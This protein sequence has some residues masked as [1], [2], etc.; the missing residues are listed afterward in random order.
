MVTLLAPVA[1][2]PTCVKV[3]N[4]PGLYRRARN[5]RYYAYK[6]KAA[7]GVNAAWASVTARLLN[8]V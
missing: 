6:S 3:A 5:G 7:S 4:F 8:G 1:K 2:A